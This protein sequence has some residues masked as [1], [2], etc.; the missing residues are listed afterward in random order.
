MASMWL[1]RSI[2]V[3]TALIALAACGSPVV[4]APLDPAHV[5]VV[6]IGF[7][8]DTGMFPYPGGIDPVL[9]RATVSD[10]AGQNVRSWS[11]D[12]ATLED[13]RSTRSASARPGGIPDSPSP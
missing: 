12:P 3:T 7:E 2:V 4:P 9:V 13:L 11:A 8:G 1:A 5:P 6:E 10:Q